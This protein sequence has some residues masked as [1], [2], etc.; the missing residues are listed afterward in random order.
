MVADNISNKSG[1][2]SSSDA[3][4]NVANDFF[5]KACPIQPQGDQILFLGRNPMSSGCDLQNFSP[6]PM[7]SKDLDVLSLYKELR[8]SVNYFLV[9][10][11]T[12]GSGKEPAGKDRSWGGSGVSVAKETQDCL[13]LT[14]NHVPTNVPDMHV[15]PTDMKVSM[16]NG[17][18]YKAETI[19]SD[20]ANELAIVKVETGAETDKVCKAAKI[21]EHSPSA[22]DSPPIMTMGQPYT[23]HSIYTS[24]GTLDEVASRASLDD[25]ISPLPG[26]DNN[27]L[28][29]NDQMPIREGFSGGPVFN[30]VGEVI[31]L[32]DVVTSP[33]TS[34]STPV[35]RAQVDALIARRTDL[36]KK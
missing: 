8:P 25:M 34:M 12:D 4:A 2:G 30:F 35:T 24:I 11:V 19:A 21:V 6:L 1:S 31:A 9:K 27:R 10:G 22:A 17:Q 28:I 20:P 15:K 23:S 16:A 32:N 3:S 26:E 33:F 13:V 7:G 14:D 29:F 36:P 5:G 18:S